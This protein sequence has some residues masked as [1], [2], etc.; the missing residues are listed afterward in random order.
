MTEKLDALDRYNK[1]LQQVYK[2]LEQLDQLSREKP[3]KEQV[4]KC[5]ERMFSELE[6]GKILLSPSLREHFEMEE[7]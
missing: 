6:E 1:A 7:L 4:I 3:S 2:D 5:L